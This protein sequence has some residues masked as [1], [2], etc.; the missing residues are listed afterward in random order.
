MSTA[1]E[2]RYLK[3]TQWLRRGYGALDPGPSTPVGAISATALQALLTAGS[4]GQ[5]FQLAA[6]TVYSGFEALNQNYGLVLKSGQKLIGAADGTTILDGSTLITGWT[7][8]TT[9]IWK[10]TGVLPAPYLGTW[11]GTTFSND[12]GQSEIPYGDTTRPD[13]AG[14]CYPREQ[15]WRDGVHLTR[16]MRLQDL[17]IPVVAGDDVALR[18]YQDFTA[19]VIYVNADPSGHEMR[20]STARYLLQAADSG[21]PNALANC[22]L[23]NVTVR[24]FASKSQLGAV[25][26]AGSG[27]EVSNCTFTGNHAIGLHLANAD[28]AWIHGNR[29]HLNG[30]LGMGHNSSDNT[31]VEDN[32]FYANNT[33]SYWAADW[34]SGGYKC[35][36]SLNNAFRRNKVWNNVGVGAWW[37]IDN[38]DAVVELNDIW[39]NQ[40]DGIR[41][42]ISY[43]AQIRNNW[44]TGNGL[45][46]PYGL[47]VPASPY[48]MLAVAG[49]NVNS[50]P[51]VKVHDNM[52]S[53]DSTRLVATSLAP[54]AAVHTRGNQNGVGAQM[55]SRGNGGFGPRD[56][57]NFES[58]NNDVTLTGYFLADVAA[59]GKTPT[60]TGSEFGATV[61]GL[62]TLQVDTA[63]Y[64]SAAKA[65]RFYNNTY[66][67]DATTK[68]R[69]AWNQ[70]YMSLANVQAAGPA[71]NPQE[72]GSTVTGAPRPGLRVNAGGD[73]GTWTSVGTTAFTGSTAANLIGDF[74]GTNF[75]HCAWIRLTD[76]QIPQGATIDSAYL[77][78]LAKGQN[79]ATPPMLIRGHNAGDSTAPTTRAGIDARTRTSAQTAWSP[80]SWPVGT[81]M[82]T[83]S[84]AAVLQEIVNRLDW[85]PGNAITFFIEPQTLGF[86]VQQL[87]SFTAYDDPSKSSAGLIY[88]YH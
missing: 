66:R 5:V 82:L 32:E 62:R 71:D 61:N 52:L 30:Q 65:N 39:D 37:D 48:S 70:T 24:R 45:Y 75:G 85:V 44:I 31:R 34:E 40:A 73:D 59:Q 28:N 79:G 53:P 18:F 6:S 46:F 2:W 4:T 68:S 38:R 26:L 33:D 7:L 86:S 42:E 15:M 49:V 67:L 84:I 72:V 23:M 47:R 17:T 43:G 55:R 14:A 12:G 20:M 11:G 57:N 29:F 13:L 36:F 54:A 64:Y 81:W 88:T 51:N 76:V 50:S 41:Y 56:L 69:F 74:D 35:T 8:H 60:S 58:Y 80:S 21:Y 1:T 9:G 19:N 16:V 77:E 27:W 22:A 83:P 3:G 25:T 10:K 78:V 87:V 63:L